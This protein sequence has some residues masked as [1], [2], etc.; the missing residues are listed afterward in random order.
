MESR[1]TGR[2]NSSLTT[3]KRKMH[4]KTAADF[5]ATLLQRILLFSSERQV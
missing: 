1:T 2:I 5:S 3:V 4:P